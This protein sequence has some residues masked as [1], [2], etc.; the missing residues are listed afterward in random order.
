LEEESVVERC[1]P[2][3]LPLTRQR[4][5]ETIKALD[6]LAGTRSLKSDPFFMIHSKWLQQWRSFVTEEGDRP[7]PISNAEL[8]CAS[9]EDPST[10]VP[11]EDL[12]KAR[13]YRGLHA[14]VWEG[15][16]KL[17]GGGPPILRQSMNIYS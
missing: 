17:Y 2:C 10:L 8:L 4:E 15:L 3:R 14:P 11:R 5:M 16:L 7:G 1:E 12:V 13:D 6:E 9:S